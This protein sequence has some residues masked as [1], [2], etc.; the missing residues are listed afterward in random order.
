M[1]NNMAQPPAAIN[2]YAKDRRLEITWAP[3]QVHRHAAKLVRAA[4]GCASCVDE[5]T[6]QRTLDV[7]SIPDDIDIVALRPVGNYAVQI[8]W[9]DGHDTG[10]YTWELLRRLG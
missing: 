8:E 4:C 3:G 9:S 5:R 6:G 1:I 7:N 10:I 2:Y